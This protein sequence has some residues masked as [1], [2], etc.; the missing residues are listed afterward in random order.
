MAFTQ[1][2][3]TALEGA[4]AEGTLRVKYA[5]REVTYQSLDAMRR[6]LVQMRAEVANPPGQPRPRRRGLI[7][8]TQTGSGR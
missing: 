5:D 1:E 6:L 2:Q 8:L 7:R 3:V 4:I